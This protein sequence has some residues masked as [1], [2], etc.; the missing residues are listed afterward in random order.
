M[1]T[2]AFVTHPSV[3][4]KGTENVYTPTQCMDDRCPVKAPHLHCPLCVKTDAYQDPVILKAHYRVKHVD[5]GIDFAGLKILRCCDQC[6]IIGIIK[7]EKRFK[8]AHWHCYRCR[9]GFNRRDEAIKH[10]KTH[11]RNP[12]TTFQIQITQDLNSPPEIRAHEDH[13]PAMQD[14]F[15]HVHNPIQ[16]IIRPPISQQTVQLSEPNVS[17]ANPI[18][19]GKTIQKIKHEPSLDKEDDSGGQED[20]ETIMIIQ[21]SQLETALASH[22][23][24]SGDLSQLGKT[25]LDSN[26]S[27]EIRCRMEEEE[28]NMYKAKAEEYK[29]QVDLLKQ[30]VSNLESQLAHQRQF[31]F[32][33][34]LEVLTSEDQAQKQAASEQVAKFLE[35]CQAILPTGSLS[36]LRAASSHSLHLQS[37]QPDEAGDQEEHQTDKARNMS[38]LLPG[39]ETGSNSCSDSLVLES[40]SDMQEQ[41]QHPHHHQGSHHIANELQVICTTSEGQVIMASNMESA[42][43]VGRREQD[44]DLDDALDHPSSLSVQSHG[45]DQPEASAMFAHILGQQ[46]Q[47]EIEVQGVL[48]EMTSDPTDQGL[49]TGTSMDSQGDGAGLITPGCLMEVVAANGLASLGQDVAAVTS[50]VDAEHHHHQASGT[51]MMTLDNGQGLIIQHASDDAENQQESSSDESCSQSKDEPEKKRLK[52]S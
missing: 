50:A 49:D 25:S 13:G 18:R 41:K 48:P 7:G 38:G 10:Y 6:D 1:S 23:I 24:D 46:E 52:V 37:Q 21:G 22:I 45:E 3:R 42:S 40:N 33:E 19:H 32:H 12:Q 8:G 9:N 4:I 31:C 43:G 35:Q 20:E 29:I 16:A 44:S 5:K 30:R 39:F 47:Q 2:L 17:V 14:A 11:F 28:K 51:F 27:W 34:L 26:L 36:L 15:G